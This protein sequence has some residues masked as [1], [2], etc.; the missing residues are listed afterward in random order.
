MT[1]IAIDGPTG[2]GK[3]T[4]SRALAERLG[5]ELVLDPVSVSPLLDSYYTGE[6]TPS[7]ALDTELAFLH[8]RADLLR[9]VADD[10][11]VVC[12]F[13]VMRTAP[14]AEFL[15]DPVDRERVLAEMHAAIESLPR[16]HV[17]V[18]LQASPDELLARVRTRDRA[19]EVDLTIDHLRELRSHFASWHD[20]MLD[21]AG[22]TTVIDT[23]HWDPRRSG[24]FDD[25]LSRVCT[26]LIH[27]LSVPDTQRLAARRRLADHVTF[28]VVDA[29]ST[30]AIAS[31][32]AY[33]AEL[34][35]RFDT[36]FD[37]GDTLTADAEHFDAP[38][39][40]F[41]V[42][43]HD[44][45]A[46][47]CGGLLTIDEGIGEIK[48]MWI[49]PTWRRVGLAARLLAELERLSQEVGHRVVRLDTNA[50]LTSAITMYEQAGYRSIEP[51]NDNPYAQR[52]FEK[53]LK[54]GDEA[55]D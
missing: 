35:A 39:G 50:T 49:A 24:D 55:A 45:E 43:H 31:M 1:I 54:S 22:S 37:P 18:L 19:A 28:D 26:M 47:G 6:A 52:W 48:R 27:D 15:A 42:V 7:A 34:D 40:R 46:I 4:T 20:A 32:N 16:P 33:F 38:S 14:F 8:A 5:A 44:E 13:T 2:V 36:G 3:S 25:L 11:L 51:Y 9:D 12:D 41:V 21:Q 23:Q 53:S 10:R 17:L 30:E 29:R